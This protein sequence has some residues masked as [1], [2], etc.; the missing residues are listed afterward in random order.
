MLSKEPL[1]PSVSS[2]EEDFLLRNVEALQK[3]AIFAD[4]SE[5]FTVGFVEIALENDL[6][7]TIRALDSHKDNP[8]IQWISLHFDDPDLR[9]LIASITEALQ[10]VEVIPNKKVVLLISGLERAIGQYGDYPPLLSNLNIARDTYPRKL[11][12]PMLFFLPS[13][14]M[15]RFARSAPDFWAWKS[16]EVRL[17]SDIKQPKLQVFLRHQNRIIPS[18]I[19]KGSPNFVGRTEELICLHKVLQ[20]EG[21]VSVSGMGGIGKTELVIHYAQMFQEHYSAC[22][23]FSLADGSLADLLLRKALPYLAMPERVLNLDDIYEQVQWCWLNWHPTEGEI[24]I[25]LDDVRSINDIPKQAM[26]ISTRF[27]I[28]L[29]TRKKNLSL[30]FRELN[31]S[32]FQE[33]KSIELLKS[34]V[35]EERINKEINSA[36]EICRYIGYLPLAIELIAAYLKEDEILSIDQYLKELS[37]NDR[38][39]SDEML[40]S[41]HVERGIISSFDLSWISLRDNAK[42]IAMLLSRFALA[43]IPWK[44]LVEPTIKLLEWDEE[45]VIKARVQLANFHLISIRDRKNIAIHPLVREYFRY[46]GNQIGEKFIHSLQK[47][48]VSNMVDIAK[49]I[50][51]TP[52]KELLNKISAYIPHLHEVS[53]FMLDDIPNPDDNLNWV[54]IG[55]ARFYEGQGLYSLAEYPYK[56]CLASVRQILGE[57]HPAIATSL[58]NLAGL[59]Y[60]EGR[61][62]EAEP[63]YL[64][65]LALRQELLGDRH[66]NVATSL[67]NLAALYDS[68]GRYAEAEPLYKQALLLRQELLGDRHPD[69]AQSLNGLAALYD[70][71]GRYT[72][73]EPL[74]KQALLLRQ[75]LLGDRH[76]D[77]AQSL[78]NL[79]RLYDS[80]GRYEEAE[81]LY[82]Q[83]LALRRELLGDRHPDVAQSLNNLARLYD[84][85]GRY[86]EAEPLYKQALVLSQ[87]LLGDRHPSVATSLNNLA[88]LYRSQRRYEEAEPL[89]KRALALR[90]ELLGDRHPDVAQSLNNL[91]E[92]YRSQG[93]YAEAEPLYKQALLLKQELLGDRH[94][95]VAT[96]LNNLALLYRSQG[97]YAEAE[98][99]YKQAL[100]LKQELLGDHHPSVATSLFNLAVLYHDMD[101]PSEA[102][103]LIQ[104]A[105]QIFEETLGVNHPNTKAA[106]SW[107]QTIQNAL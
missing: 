13:Y 102:L 22:Y 30:S 70:S 11:P 29:T 16:I 63:L 75:E 4:L 18:N 82:K 55:I 39:S 94:P 90:Q 9:Y 91:A 100:L 32:L 101:R 59:Y 81:P 38:S 17:Q 60:S 104:R 23:W 97:R 31:L 58:N 20:E 36:R 83:A 46:Q 42:N 12:Y 105:I 89:Y 64:K 77:V 41:L 7:L 47:S 67:N 52:T 8:E 85:Q 86:E 93:R 57:H 10:E 76:P 95:D 54:F 98:P 53:E 15:T 14:A 40:E 51:Q 69:V 107:L 61:Y 84:S 56:K 6:N 62:A 1:T 26:P 43:E 19:R 78:N 74:Y 88:G 50:P 27:K 66:P 80:Q 37:L 34:I 3:I 79:A 73:A 35:G 99:L 2:P 5:G 71:Q 65:A 33:D 44:D 45:A 92:L 87:E 96:S 21:S 103:N 106:L 48:I 49:L 25:I 72:E 24:L 28:I 68:Q